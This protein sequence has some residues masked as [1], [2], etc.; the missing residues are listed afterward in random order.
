MNGHL[1]CGKAC[2]I[3]NPVQNTSR[4][5]RFGCFREAELLAFNPMNGN[6]LCNSSRINMGT[7]VEAGVVSVF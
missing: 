6:Q 2:G 3:E 1:A 5:S 4:Q 7:G